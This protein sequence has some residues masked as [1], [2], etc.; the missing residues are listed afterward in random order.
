MNASGEPDLSDPA[1]TG[2]QLGLTRYGDAE[3]SLFLR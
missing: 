2:M 3:F 1:P